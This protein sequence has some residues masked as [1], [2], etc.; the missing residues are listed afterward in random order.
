M[1]SS[2]MFRLRR[3]IKYGVL[4]VLL[5]ILTFIC[6]NNIPSSTEGTIRIFPN[7]LHSSNLAG[8]YSNGYT[9]SQSLREKLKPKLAK[10]FSPRSNQLDWSDDGLA[11]NPE[12]VKLRE[13]GYKNFAFNTLVSS[14]LSLHRPINDT[15]HKACKKLAYPPPSEL[16]SASVI[17]CFYREDFT[18]LLRTIHSVIDRS[19]KEVLRE[20]ILVNDQ[21]DMNIVPNIT[22]HLHSENLNHIVHLHEAPEV[23]HT[24]SHY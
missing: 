2:N 9:N 15:R 10:P 5:I 6:Y 17:I 11:Q 24:F 4:L 1:N 23:L 18:V 3:A 22:A 16:P 21:S 8:V 7:K 19:P 20:I 14:R 12:D 13:D